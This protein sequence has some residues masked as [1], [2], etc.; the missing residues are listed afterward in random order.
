[1]SVDVSFK[2]KVGAMGGD[3][4]QSER[5]SGMMPNANPG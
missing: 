3:S 2:F 5:D 1:M 4:G